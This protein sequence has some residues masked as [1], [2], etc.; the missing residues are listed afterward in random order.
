MHKLGGYLLGL[1]EQIA[2]YFNKNRIFLRSLEAPMPIY[3][4]KKYKFIKGNDIF[5]FED[6]AIKFFYDPLQEITI[7]KY[8]E[9]Q[10]GDIF[11]LKDINR[12]YTNPDKK[13]KGNILMNIKG[14]VD[15]GF[16][17]YKDLV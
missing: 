5:N 17:M 10:W 3:I 16:E 12:I 4:H 11:K 13:K 8:Y 9:D 7:K 1:T 2:K 6:S 15:D 14:N